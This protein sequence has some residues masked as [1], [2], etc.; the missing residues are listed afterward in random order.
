[1]EGSSVDAVN[2]EEPTHAAHCRPGC[3]F[4]SCRFVVTAG[5]RVVQK[6]KPSHTGVV[7]GTGLMADY[8]QVQKR[9]LKLNGVAELGMTKRKKKKKDK[10]KAKLLEAMG[11][12]KKNKEEK[13]C[14]LDK[15]T[16]A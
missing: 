12:S 10:D 1:M 3:P 4:R 11:M 6:I 7:R 13:R 14:G 8:E 15:W 2:A 9:P 5:A 16:L